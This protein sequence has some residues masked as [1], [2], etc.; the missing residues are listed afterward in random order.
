MIGL[1]IGTLVF[2]RIGDLLGRKKTYLIGLAMHIMLT[3]T[4]LI[5][6]DPNWFYA[7]IF[8]MGIEYPARFLVGYIYL[9][10]MCSEFARP[11]VTSI[12]LFCV[13]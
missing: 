6:R 11:I 8:L 3:A 12:G 4:L 9:S 10:E 2:P 7:I 5:L 1:V 13:A